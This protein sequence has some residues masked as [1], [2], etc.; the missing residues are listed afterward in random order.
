MLRSLAFCALV[1]AA[2]AGA[3][4]FDPSERRPGTRLSGAPAALPADWSFTDSQQ[5]IAVEVSGLLGLPHSVTIWCA[6]LDG[7]L[8][9]GAR[10]PETKRWPA[11]ADADPD[12]RLGID[13]KTYEVRLTP[14][15]DPAVLERLRAVYAAKY[16]LPAPAPGEKPPTVRYWRV[17]PR[18]TQSG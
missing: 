6:A 7:V 8:F 16:E 18:G 3:A 14:E 12:V 9:I 11:W 17:G 5:E 4:C 2:M 15:N 10:D 13:G 1:T